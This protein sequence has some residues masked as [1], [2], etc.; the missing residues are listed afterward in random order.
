[1]TGSERRQAEAPPS[2]PVFCPPHPAARILIWLAFALFLPWLPSIAM[3]G[4]SLLMLPL[5]LTLHRSSFVKLL[6]RTRW[7]LLSI[8]LIYAWTMPGE[9]LIQALGT[10]SPTLEGLQAGAAQAWRLAILLAGLALLLATTPGL[11]LLGGMYLLLR[12]WRRLGVDNERITARIWLTLYYAEQAARLKP[13]EWREKLQHALTAETVH[14]RPVYFEVMPL[15][16][17]DWLMLAL[18]LMTLGGLAL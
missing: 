18:A 10:L 11:Q 14:G 1:M 13:H 4:I 17:Q 2:K 5:L 16:G 6:R 15:R 12:P 3:L 8:L 9:N 7:L